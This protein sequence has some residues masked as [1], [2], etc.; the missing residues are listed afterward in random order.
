MCREGRGG[1]GV[2]LWGGGGCGVGECKLLRW[3]VHANKD[4]GN[5]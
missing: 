4:E 3:C 1:M 2:G 5:L